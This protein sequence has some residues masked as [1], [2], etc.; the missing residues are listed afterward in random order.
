MALSKEE[1]VTELEEFRKAKDGFF[2][3]DPHSP[4]TAEQKQAFT[5]LSYFPENPDLRLELPVEAFPE[6]T[7]IQMQTSTG[8]VQTYTR[9]G[10]IR[11]TV[12]GQDAALTVYGDAHGYFIP[13]ADALAGEQTYGAGRYLE[14]HATEDGQLLVDF[15]FAYN[16]Y[17]AYNN[18]F[19]CPLT[20]AEN[21][22]KVPVRAGEKIPEGDWVGHDVYA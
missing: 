7:K 2:A 11:F 12:D 6:K 3:A 17:C 18:R 5:G 16:P 13:F 14:P 15:N 9:Q 1:R 19:S 20:P 22:L 10:Q 4:L 8:D 21:R